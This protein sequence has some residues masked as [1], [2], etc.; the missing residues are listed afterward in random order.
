MANRLDRACAIAHGTSASAAR[1][2]HLMSAHLIE[3]ARAS[4]SAQAAD[5]LACARELER[6]SVLIL[7]A[8]RRIEA[9]T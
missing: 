4:P 3:Q 5:M 9:H 7:E 6:A 1:Q 8:L 2:V